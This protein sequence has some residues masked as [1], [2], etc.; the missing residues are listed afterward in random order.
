M[1]RFYF[2]INDG[3][4]RTMDNEGHDLESFESARKLAVQELALI[5]RD[6]MPDGERESYVVV[7]RDAQGVPVYV[8]TATMIGEKL[9]EDVE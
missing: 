6:D 3:R 2:D 5:I 1:P 9:L 4:T 7:L 8:A